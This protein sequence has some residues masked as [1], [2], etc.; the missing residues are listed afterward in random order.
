MRILIST[1]VGLGVGALFLV[2][3]LG[4]VPWCPSTVFMV[5]HYP[6]MVLAGALFPGEGG[7]WDSLPFV[8][9]QWP[10]I[11]GLV[12]L[13]LQIKHRSANPVLAPTSKSGKPADP[14]F[15]RG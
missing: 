15:R 5:L 8:T 10:I 9:L 2:N 11:G 3:V 6:F 1:A 12:G 7:F 4:W 14:Q 13:V